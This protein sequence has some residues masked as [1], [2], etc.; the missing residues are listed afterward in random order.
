[1]YLSFLEDL[2]ANETYIL[3][4]KYKIHKF[5]FGYKHKIINVVF[6]ISANHRYVVSLIPT[7]RMVYSIQ[8]YMMTLSTNCGRSVVYYVE[9]IKST[10]FILGTNTKSTNLRI[11]E[12]VIFNQS[13]KIDAHEEKNFHSIIN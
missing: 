12:L 5:Y 10:N 9:N 3:C 2:L 6:T 11:H 13:T 8:F 1:M 4:W 7:H